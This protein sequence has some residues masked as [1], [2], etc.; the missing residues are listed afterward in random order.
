[1]RGLALA[2][3]FVEVDF[4]FYREPAEAEEQAL[5]AAVAAARYALPRAQR[6]HRPSARAS[7]SPHAKLIALRSC[8]I[9]LPNAKPRTRQRSFALR[10]RLTRAIRMAMPRW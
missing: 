2:A 6:A 5:A 4:A 7:R 10:P 9:R 8:R 3:W 1:M